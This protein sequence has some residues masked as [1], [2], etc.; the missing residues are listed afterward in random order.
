MDQ[1][2]ASVAGGERLQAHLR[3]IGEK[4]KAAT[5]VRVGFL[6]GSTTTTEGINIPTYAAINNFGAPEANIP[7]RPFFSNMVA[8]KSPE[9]SAKFEAILKTV[10]YDVRKALELMGES[11]AGQLR[12]AI[13]AFDSVPDSAVTDLLKQRFPK[14][15]GMT[16]A[17]VL[18]ARHDI[19]NG[20]TAPPGKPLVWSG[21]MLASVNSEVE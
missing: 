7:A 5:E 19:A 12:K 16:F 13:E 4:I 1:A 10:D 14:R 15:D 17:D 8:D 20:K 9:W 18:Q 3:E 6:E 21:D 11:I 2:V